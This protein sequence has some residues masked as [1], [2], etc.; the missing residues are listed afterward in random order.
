MTLITVLIASLATLFASRINRSVA[1]LNSFALGLLS[2]GLGSVIALQGLMAHSN[3]LLLVGSALR[4]G[5]MLAAAQGVRKFCSLPPLS[6]TTVALLVSVASAL[7]LY[8]TLRSQNFG[9]RVETLSFALALL[10][11]DAAA[12]MFRRAPSRNRLAYWPVGLSFAFVAVYLT[13]RGIAALSGGYGASVPSS[14]APVEVAYT[15]CADIA[16]VGC[17]FGMLLASNTRLRDEAEAMA[18]FDPLTNL[19]NRRL[20]LDRLL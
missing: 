19:P 14:S 10:A 1:G 17:S 11:A 9:M 12:S 3:A 15:I 6:R 5:G 7:L 8:W 4:R 16:F 18:L 2:M 20:L 13:S